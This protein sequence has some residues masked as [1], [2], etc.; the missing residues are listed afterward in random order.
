MCALNRWAYACH[1]DQRELHAVGA[2]KDKAGAR[3]APSRAT[4]HRAM[5]EA[6]PDPDALQGALNRW[7]AARVPERT[8]LAADGERLRGANHH[9]ERYY[10]TVTL[11]THE[12][13]MPRWP[14]VCVTTKAARLRPWPCL[15]RS[16]S[17]AR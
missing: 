10:E 13:A 2:W 9:G 8:A 15:R 16:M 17:G 14:V 4:L 5:M 12:G 1:L 7:V 6:D 3:H 11:V